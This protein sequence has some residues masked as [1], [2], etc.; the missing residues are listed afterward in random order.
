MHSCQV[1]WTAAQS[2]G[3]R[4]LPGQCLFSGELEQDCASSKGSGPVGEAGE[5]CM[6]DREQAKEEAKGGCLNAR[7]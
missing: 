1:P 3:Q 6:K 4:T 5:A 2:R 7:V